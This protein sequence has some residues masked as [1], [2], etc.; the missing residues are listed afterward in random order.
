MVERRYGG[1]S[2]GGPS[3]S[4]RK[5]QGTINDTNM[6]L[7]MKKNVKSKNLNVATAILNNHTTYPG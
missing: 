2:W 7:K 3:V 6:K 5:K 1:R 4:L